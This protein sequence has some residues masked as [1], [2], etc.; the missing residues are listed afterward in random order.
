MHSTWL[1]RLMRHQGIAGSTFHT[2]TSDR[3]EIIMNGI[4]N[5]DRGCLPKIEIAGAEEEM[6]HIMP[7]DFI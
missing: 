4:S 6:L 7:L 1:A 2:G 5:D 3:V